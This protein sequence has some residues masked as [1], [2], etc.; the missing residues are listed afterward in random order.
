MSLVLS[1]RYFSVTLLFP[2]GINLLIH[3]IKLKMIRF[4]YR[5]AVVGGVTS[6]RQY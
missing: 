5:A 3:N 2:Y 6:D 4:K 1:T